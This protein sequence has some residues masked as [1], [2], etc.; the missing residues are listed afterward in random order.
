[1]SEAG[2]TNFRE[3]CA[4]YAE[5]K[6]HQRS[7]CQCL[8]FNSLILEELPTT[9]ADIPCHHPRVPNASAWSQCVCAI[10]C[11]CV[12]PCVAS[13]SVFGIPPQRLGNDKKPAVS[14]SHVSKGNNLLLLDQRTMQHTLFYPGVGRKHDAS[15]WC[16]FN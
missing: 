10:L 1:M 15:E 14:K 7:A 9:D 11:C 5:R 3:P 13:T 12:A 8:A 6:I 4:S 16:V 2:R